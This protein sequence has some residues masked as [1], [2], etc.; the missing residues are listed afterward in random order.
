MA[1]SIFVPENSEWSVQSVKLGEQMYTIELVYKQRTDRWYMTLSDTEGNHLL[2][3]KKCVTGQTLTGLHGLDGFGGYLYVQRTYGKE[4]YPSRH[5]FGAGKE[6]ELLYF[7]E[8]EYSDLL[9]LGNEFLTH[10]YR[11][12]ING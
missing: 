7:S 2:T 11:D 12:M 1:Y 3:E 5:N 9:E 10:D 8:D 6:F 4:D